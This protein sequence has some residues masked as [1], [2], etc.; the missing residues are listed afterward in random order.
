[1]NAVSM[2]VGGLLL[3]IGFLAGAYVYGADDEEEYKDAYKKEYATQNGLYQ[4]RR[5]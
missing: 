1:M 3:V 5:R 4:P 2:L